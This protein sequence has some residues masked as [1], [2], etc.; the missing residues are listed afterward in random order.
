MAL[1]CSRRLLPTIVAQILQQL[2]WDAV[3]QSVM[4][5]L[6]DILDRNLASICRK[7]HFFAELGKYT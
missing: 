5:V 3:H 7:V 4:D 2:G 1:P 6:V